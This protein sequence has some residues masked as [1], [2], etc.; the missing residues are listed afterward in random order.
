M[1]VSVVRTVYAAPQ[2]TDLVQVHVE[3]HTAHSPSLLG[4]NT[5][6]SHFYCTLKRDST[7]EV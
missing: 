1:T 4:N 2:Y 7:F 3:L 6:K 5:R